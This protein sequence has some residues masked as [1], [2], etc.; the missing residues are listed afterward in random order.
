MPR[1]RDMVVSP[2]AAHVHAAA[3][4]QERIRVQ[5]IVTDVGQERARYRNAWLR[6]A[7]VGTSVRITASTDSPLGLAQPGAAIDVAIDMTGTLDLPTNTYLGR[8]A[9]LISIQ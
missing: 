8:N 9:R 3:T 7:T 2:H 1:A 6:I 5:G 4:A